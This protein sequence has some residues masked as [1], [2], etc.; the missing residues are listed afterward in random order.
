ML[1]V[2]FLFVCYF[3]PTNIEVCRKSADS[4][5]KIIL[6]S[7]RVNENHTVCMRASRALAGFVS[8]SALAEWQLCCRGLCE[9]TLHDS[10]LSLTLSAQIVYL[11][12]HVLILF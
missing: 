5:H 12:V 7:P 10:R 4:Y 2:R 8:Y 6:L 3:S 1:T 11:E 9:C